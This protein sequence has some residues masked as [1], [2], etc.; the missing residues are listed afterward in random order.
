MNVSH[1]DSEPD[2]K[3]RHG[4]IVGRCKVKGAEKH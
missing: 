2:K 3:Y 1:I 4:A